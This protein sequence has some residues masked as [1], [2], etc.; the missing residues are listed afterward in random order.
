MGYHHISRVI[1][2]SSCGATRSVLVVICFKALPVLTSF[3]ACLCVC[4][5]LCCSL[6]VRTC[7]QI[8]LAVRGFFKS[9]VEK[10]SVGLAQAILGLDLTGQP[11]VKDKAAFVE[12]CRL[13]WDKQ[14]V[15]IYGKILT[16][17]L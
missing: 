2:F 1:I 17:V 14:Y 11:F 4:L 8:T 15:H 13:L 10:D 3:C 9:I 7:H 6:P 12:E 16:E 5:L